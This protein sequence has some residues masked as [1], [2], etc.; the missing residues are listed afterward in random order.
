MFNLIVSGGLENGRSGT[1][2]ANRVF[3]HTHDSLV[4]RFRPQ[5]RLDIAS[6]VL[7]P[8]ILMG[9]GVSNE[10][11]TLGWLTRIE[12]RGT[13][14]RLQYGRDTEL[15]RL[16]NADIYGLS[17]ELQ[18]GDWEFSRNHWAIK[19]VDLFHVLYRQSQAQQPKPRV[20]QL[21][22]N[23]VKPKLITFMMPFSAEFSSVYQT[24]KLAL[25]D[26]DYQCQRAD[27]FWQHAHIMQDIIELICTSQ[28][29]IC[30]LSGKN[31]NVFYEAGIAH[32][33]GKEVILITQHMDDVPFDLR[34]LRC[35]TYLNNSEGR[36]KLASSVL[37]RVQTLT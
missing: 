22:T 30:D 37:A 25:E 8:T 15:P 7:L 35:I 32:T 5:G 34:A 18:I 17:E 2:S 24:I 26:N 13:E 11:A 23:P 12:L 10:I 27:D 36:E 20:F 14:Y 28:V 4:A 1:I 6:L 29:V 19:D 3:E 9:E 16:T 33:L 31:P 21:S